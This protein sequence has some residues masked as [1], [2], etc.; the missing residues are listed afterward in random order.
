LILTQLGLKPSNLI[1]SFA[2]I[3]RLGA[4]SDTSS[5]IDMRARLYSTLTGRFNSVDP[6]KSAG[7]SINYYEYAGNDPQRNSDPLGKWLFLAPVVFSGLM[8]AG[9]GTVETLELFEIPWWF[10]AGDEGYHISEIFDYLGGGGED[11]TGADQVVQANPFQTTGDGD[12]PAA[13]P[14]WQF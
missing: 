2:F 13:A 12:P 1:D 4:L 6:L 5:L 11:P 14:A 3:G 7:G 8:L 10:D 9:E